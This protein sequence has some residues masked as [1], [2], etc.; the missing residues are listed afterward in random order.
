MEQQPELKFATD[1]LTDDFTSLESS[2]FYFLQLIFFN[3]H[4][5]LQRL[6]AISDVLLRSRN[7]QIMRYANDA[8]NYFIP[9]MSF[10]PSKVMT[11]PAIRSKIALDFK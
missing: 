3:F 2:V 8:K 7:D 6:K 5:H 9:K 4:I 10:K 1:F 11:P